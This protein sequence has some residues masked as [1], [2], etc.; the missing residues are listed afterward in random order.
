M[1][2]SSI[3]VI[4]LIA[5]LIG[6]G[7]SW[8]LADT[9]PIELESGL[10]FGEQ[11]R[12]LPAFEL[13]DHNGDT[14]DPERLADKWSLLFF[15]YTHCPDICPISLQALADMMSSIDDEHVRE[16]IQ[17]YF[18]SVDPERDTPELMSSY[19]TYFNP[20]FIGA[21][22]AL[23]GL[24]VLTR[25]LG[26]AHEFRNREDGNPVYDVDHSGSIVLIGPDAR[27]SGLFGA[28]QDAQKMARDMTRI[29]ER[30]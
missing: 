23:E 14:V 25:S 15:G 3:I 20:D 16:R 8:Y 26:I 30:N 6:F 10:W 21:T 1:N 24:R 9:R 12:V 2:K 18:I 28:P 17:V 11:A 19:V 22:T 13:V 7:A 29:V 5:L 27:Y 4:A